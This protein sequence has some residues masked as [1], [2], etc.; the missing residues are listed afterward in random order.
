LRKSGDGVRRAGARA[1]GV[2]TTAWGVWRHSALRL[3]A[4]AVAGAPASAEASRLAT[5]LTVLDWPERPFHTS[6]SL[7]TAI[8]RRK[9][10]S[11]SFAPVWKRS[12]SPARVWP[13][14]YQMTFLGLFHPDLRSDCSFPPSHEGRA[15]PGLP[16]CLLLRG[17]YETMRNSAETAHLV[18]P[19]RQQAAGRQ[20]AC[21]SGPFAGAHSS[22]SH[23]PPQTIVGQP[24]PRRVTSAGWLISSP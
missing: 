1:G 14:T 10:G 5:R 6:T 15:S 17:L 16:R 20:T 9:R 23:V 21:N 7:P 19:E 12:A 13:K 22:P 4:V 8:T 2:T 11:Y 24:M 3:S 18:Q